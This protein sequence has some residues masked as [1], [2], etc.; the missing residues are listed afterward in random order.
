MSVF[1]A[2]LRGINVGGRN[3]ITMPLLHGIFVDLGHTD[4]T[5]YVQS[6][7][8][9]F[10]SRRQPAAALESAI[11]AA[12]TTDLGLTVV[13]LVRTAAELSA[14][15]HDNPFLAGETDPTKLHV[16]LLKDT[17]NQDAVDQLVAPTV[18]PDEYRL[19]DRE[20]YLHCPNGYGKTKLSNAFWERKLRLPA[21]TRNWK[22]VTTLAQ[23][24]G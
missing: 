6:G 22:T 18:T 5:T 13:A 3:Q 14:I 1:V 24:A 21:T 20:I 9:V 19:R 7:N 23:L 10:R 11:E 16:T 12:I 4:V 2:L 17:P 15:R 8:I